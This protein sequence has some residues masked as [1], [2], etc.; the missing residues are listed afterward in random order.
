MLRSQGNQGIRETRRLLSEQ[1]PSEAPAAKAGA[2]RKLRDDDDL[3]L[4]PSAKRCKV[5]LPKKMKTHQWIIASASS[6]ST[7]SPSAQCCASHT[8]HQSLAQEMEKRWDSDCC[9]TAIAAKGRYQMQWCVALSLGALRREQCAEHDFERPSEAIHARWKESCMVMVVAFSELQPRPPKGMC[10]N[11]SRII[12][13][14]IV[15]RAIYMDKSLDDGGIAHGGELLFA[16]EPTGSGK[17]RLLDALAGHVAG[18]G[19]GNIFLRRVNAGLCR[20]QSMS[21]RRSICMLR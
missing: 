16:M 19:E 10:Q 2:K 3:A 4:I 11:F 14:A 9:V 1:A 7:D 6:R 20:W 13:N 15:I 21:S 12:E 8:S 18:K 17:T 5:A